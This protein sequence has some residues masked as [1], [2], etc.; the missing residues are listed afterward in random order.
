MPEHCQVLLLGEKIDKRGKFYKSLLKTAAMVECKSLKSYQ[1][2]PWLDEQAALRGC[3]FD[4]EASQTI[5]EYLSVTDNAPLLLLEQ[6]IEKLSV[7]AGERNIW[8]KDDIEQTFAA[9][10]EVSRFALLNAIAEKKLGQTLEL[11]GEERKH[12][13]TVLALCGLI[14]FQLRRLGRVKELLE[15]RASQAEIASEL[16]AAPFAV[17]KMAEQSRRFGLGE[18][19]RAL[20]ELSQLNIEIRYGGRQFEKLEEILI[21]LLSK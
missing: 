8:T 10:P 9:L 7:Y 1:L 18:L 15:G 21:R 12:G 6:E 11:L 2:K 13:N 20:L 19:E 14:S 16:K 17:K 3:R 4:Y 5:M